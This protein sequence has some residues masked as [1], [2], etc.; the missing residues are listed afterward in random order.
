MLN[1]IPIVLCHSNSLQTIFNNY[2]NNKMINRMKKNIFFAAFLSVFTFTFINAQNLS[3]GL[4]VGPSW[5]NVLSNDITALDF[6][7]IS[8]AS[9][10]V[11]ADLKLTDNIAFHPE[12]NYTEKGFKS[13]VG[14]DLSLFGTSLPIGARATTTVKYL[15]VPL[16]I[17]YNFGNT[18]GVH[19]YAMAGPSL[20][21]ALSGTVES[22]AKVLITDIKV[23]TSTI[24]LDAQNYKRFEVGGLVGAGMNIPVGNGN[25]FIDG[26]YQRSF[27]DVYEVPVIGAKVR[28]QGFGFSIGYSFNLN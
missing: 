16:A 23:G 21:Y 2:S 5:Q 15:D 9:V 17:K 28:N 13:N 1:T 8:V 7:A 6:N 11:V 26:R 10:G 24:D 4:R 19:F 27:M 12:F 20:G 22:Y 3:V 14:T 18:E 25:L